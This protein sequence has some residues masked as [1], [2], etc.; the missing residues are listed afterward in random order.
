MEECGAARQADKQT[1]SGGEESR[2]EA[3][4]MDILLTVGCVRLQP[5]VK[6]SAAPHHAGPVISLG[7]PVLGCGGQG[8]GC[9]AL[10]VPC[11]YVIVYL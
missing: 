4:E 8:R 11:V 5:F 3:K 7:P 10:F 9:R 1:D 2:H 6:P